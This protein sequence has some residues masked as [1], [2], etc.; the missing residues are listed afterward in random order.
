MKRR[1]T[2]VLLALIILTACGPAESPEQTPVLI[3]QPEV[4]EG[5]NTPPPEPSPDPAY[6]NSELTPE[7]RAEDLLSRMTMEEKIGQMT[8]I[9]KGSITPDAVEE[10]FIGGVLSGGGGTPSQNTPEGWAEMVDSYQEGALATRLQIPVIYGVDAVHGHNNLKGAVIYPHNVG[11]GA[12]RDTDLVR[13]IGEATA[14][15]MAATNIHWNYAPVLAVVQDIRW[16]RTYEAY[17]EDTDL[18]TSLG[19]AFQ[20]G[21]Q[22]QE[23]SDPLTALATPK[24]YIGDGATVW[25]SS[26]TG[27]YQIDQGVMVATEEEI[28]EKY[29]PPYQAAVDAGALSIMISFSSWDDTKM[30]AHQY[31]ITDVLKGEL[32]FEGFVVSDWGGVDQINPNYYTSV[33]EAINAGI[34]MNMVPTSYTQFIDAMTQAVESG[35]IT[36]ERVDD[37]VRRILIVKFSLGLFETPYSNPDL[38]DLV[39][40]E[41]ARKLAQEAVAKSLVLLKNE[42]SALPLS[43]DEGLIFLAGEGA[44][45]IGMQ[46][47]GWTISWQGM[48]GA[49]TPGTTIKDAF[50][51]TFGGQLQYN[52]FGRYDNILDEDDDLAIA[53]VGVVVIGEDPYAE[54]AGDSNDLTLSDVDIE[55]IQRVGERSQKLVVLVMAGRPLVIT[56]ALDLA[57]AWVAVWLPGTE[58]QGVADVLFGVEPF[59]GKTPLTWPRSMDQLPLGSYDTEPLFPYGFGLEY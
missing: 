15:A 54:G 12:S 27:N 49:I 5:T 14:E 45:D 46:C 3:D 31:L 30:H 56:E 40:T 29:L 25:G 26:I 8:L 55:L 13:R 35:D 48:K 28:R 16:G 38:F 7:E 11:L 23:L 47:G 20:E 59:I 18:V 36:E 43:A 6:L 57:D 9:E 1:F 58:G 4:V 24:H 37:A 19:V 33:V 50:E 10:Y 21:L 42:N 52:R 41:E 53:D 32:D 17:G 44:D 51:E 39:G 22:G 2:I 34:D